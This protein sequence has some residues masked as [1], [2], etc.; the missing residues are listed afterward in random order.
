MT[1]LRTV[2]PILVAGLLV[3]GLLWW[4]QRPTPPAPAGPAVPAAAGGDPIRLALVPEHDVFALRKSYQK[5]ATYL[6]QELGRPVQIVTLNTF[7]AVLLDFEEKQ[8]EGAFLGSLVAVL[9]MDRHD[10]RPVVKPQRAD[11]SSTYRGVIFVKEDSPIQSL[12]DLRGRKVAGVRTTTAGCL[13]SIQQFLKAGLLEGER[14]PTALS[15]G[16]HDDVVKAVMNGQADAGSVKDLRLEAYLAA[17]PG[18]KVRILARSLEV[19]NNA[20]LMRAELA[21]GLG[22]RIGEALVKMDQDPLGREALAELKAERFVAASAEE[23]GPVWDMLEE[24]DRSR[25]KVAM[26]CI[27]SAKRPGPRPAK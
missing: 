5:L 27:P 7:E 13:F 22:Q 20:L 18:V 19:P 2:L 23:Y 1:M 17:N 8:I 14:R 16:T 12:A 15:V 10:A 9:A 3:A 6:S 21:N 25:D 26:P 11:G 4:S 24:L